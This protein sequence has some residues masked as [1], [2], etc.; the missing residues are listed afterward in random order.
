MWYCN[1]RLINRIPGCNDI[2]SIKDQ[3]DVENF[4]STKTLIICSNESLKFRGSDNE[5]DELIQ[6][7]NEF[8]KR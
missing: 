3:E 1:K 4:S 5:R 2:N 7:Y 8:N 6:L